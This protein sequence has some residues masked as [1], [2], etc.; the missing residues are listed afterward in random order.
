MVLVNALKV[1]CEIAPFLEINPVEI[2]VLSLTT[3]ILG[4]NVSSV[5]AM[6]TSCDLT[7]VASQ[8]IEIIV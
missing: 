5:Y 2:L 6:K 3:E 7:W 8:G 1:C 4:L